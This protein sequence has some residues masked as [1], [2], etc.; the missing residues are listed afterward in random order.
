MRLVLAGEW[1]PLWRDIASTLWNHTRRASWVDARASC[2][3][4]WSIANDTLF[5]SSLLEEL[6]VIYLGRAINFPLCIYT[7]L[8]NIWIKNF[9]KKKKFSNT[10]LYYKLP[11]IF[12]SAN[13]QHICHKPVDF[14][15]LQPTILNN[16]IS[17]HFQLENIFN[18]KLTS[19]FCN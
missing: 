8:I 16:S 19:I 13:V 7:K 18:P 10:P 1:I 11:K 9:I 2:V 4:S 5:S 14:I 3:S 17:S 12:N 15:L 6:P